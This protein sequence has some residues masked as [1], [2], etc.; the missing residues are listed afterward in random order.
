MNT[1]LLI[2]LAIVL[3]YI[4]LFALAVPFAVVYHTGAWI[5]KGIL[6]LV[7]AKCPVLLAPVSTLAV[8]LWRKVV[9]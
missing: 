7:E 3:F 4:L 2:L 1:V 8:R 6:R 5:G 9:Q